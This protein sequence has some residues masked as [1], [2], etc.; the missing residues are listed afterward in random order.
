MIA[1]PM[2]PADLTEPLDEGAY[3]GKAAQ[4]A[5]AVRA[6]LP[7]PK[8]IGLPVDLVDAVAASDADAVRGLERALAG[9]RR[10]LA[11]RSSAVGEDSAIA[12]FAGQ[13]LTCLN[14]GSPGAVVDAVRAIFASARSESALAYRRRMGVEGEPRV[15]AVVQELVMADRAG[16]LFSCNPVT[17]ADEI[18][19]E[20][21]WGLGEAVVA[22]L[23][24][25]DRFRLSRQGAVLERSIGVKDLAVRPT[26]AGG[27]CETPV[28]ASLARTP[29]LDASDLERLSRLAARCE[30]V[31]GGRQ[32]LEWAFAGDRLHLLQRRPV[33][34]APQPS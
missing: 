21:A 3:G 7:V 18:V 19:I 28:A 34:R 22:G 11:V 15:G 6:G 29:C 32:D 10:P 9:L 26:P 33:T 5:M 2:R 12:S 4:L 31:F 8:G 1:A 25:P 14:V 17:G 27:T 16:V 30:A 13:H 24:T 20:A 23:V